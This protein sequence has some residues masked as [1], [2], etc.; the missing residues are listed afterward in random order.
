MSLEQVDYM[1]E[2][3]ARTA[4]AANPKEEPR[5]VSRD[6]AKPDA[7]ASQPS[8]LRLVRMAPRPQPR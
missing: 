3:D 5:D 8:P 7:P 2:H 6:A 1:T 4:P